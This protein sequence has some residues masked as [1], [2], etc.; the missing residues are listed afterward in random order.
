MAEILICISDSDSGHVISKLSEVDETCPANTYSYPIND[1]EICCCGGNCCWNRCTWDQPPTNCLPNDTEWIYSD[2]HGY[3]QATINII[4]EYNEG[5]GEYLPSLDMISFPFFTGCWYIIKDNAI[6]D[7]QNWGEVYKVEFDLTVKKRPITVVNVYSFLTTHDGI[8]KHQRIPAFF[9]YPDLLSFRSR[10]NGQ[11]GYRKDFNYE[12]GKTYQI[13]HHQF[14]ENGKYW[15]EIIID[16]LSKWKVENTQPNS[17]P[18]VR[19]FASDNYHD[20]FT[21]DLGSICNFKLQSS[22]GQNLSTDTT[23]LILL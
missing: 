1:E 2:S 21:S 20:S 11:W 3:Y 12:V 7:F 8:I 9:I 16:G 14:I 22:G 10:V 23:I 19:F 18:S 15:Y 4:T 5:K 13:T 17:F 6:Q